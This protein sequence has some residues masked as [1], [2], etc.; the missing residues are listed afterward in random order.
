M[1][2]GMERDMMSRNDIFIILSC[3]FKHHKVKKRNCEQA[4]GV[5]PIDPTSPNQLARCRRR[6]TA[7][8]VSEYERCIVYARSI[9]VRDD[10]LS[11]QQLGF[12]VEWRIM[13][14]IT[15]L[16]TRKA[17]RR[18]VSSAGSSTYRAY[19]VNGCTVAGTLCDQYVKKTKSPFVMLWSWARNRN[20]AITD[21]FEWQ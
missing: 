13:T 9:C 4:R 12:Y 10:R 2:W 6:S 5:Q 11:L 21:S 1:G 15:C 19:I 3:I 16:T 18:L 17:R 7:E 14:T 8:W 20:R